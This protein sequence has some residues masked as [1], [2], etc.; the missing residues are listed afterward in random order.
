MKNKIK[1]L[2]ENNFEKIVEWRKCK[3]TGEDFPIFEKD[4]EMLKK[5]SPMIN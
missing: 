1:F 4:I 5:L 2:E 3:W